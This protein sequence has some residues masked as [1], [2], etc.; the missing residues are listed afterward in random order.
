MSKKQNSGISGAFGKGATPAPNVI[1]PKRAHMA[2]EHAFGKITT[3]PVMGLDTPACHW[4]EIHG[5]INDVMAF[6]YE[7]SVEVGRAV[8]AIEAAG[9]PHRVAEYN[10]TISTV[11]K[12]LEKFT[13]E[14]IQ[15]RDA[16]AQHTGVIAT[17]EDN[18]EYIRFFE[19]IKA[20]QA[21]YQGVMHHAFINIT[22]FSLEAADKAK[23]EGAEHV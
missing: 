18:V 11:M 8:T 12:D 4:S 23:K 7:N 5:F 14:C 2:I 15:I 19:K 1:M 20:A 13:E 6:I 16:A 3:M 9:G 21:F 10:R 17:P 22:E